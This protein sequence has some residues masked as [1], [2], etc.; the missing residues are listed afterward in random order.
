MREPLHSNIERRIDGF[1]GRP[2]KTRRFELLATA[3]P[4]CGTDAIQPRDRSALQ[5][6]IAMPWWPL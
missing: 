6:G 3:D 2:A 5:T 4:N 1:I